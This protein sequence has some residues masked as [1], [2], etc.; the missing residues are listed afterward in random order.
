MDR[1]IRL[2]LVLLTSHTV[3]KPQPF[4]VIIA[5][6][7]RVCTAFSSGFISRSRIQDRRQDFP[8][9]LI[10]WQIASK[11]F[12]SR[13]SMTGR[14]LLKTL[15]Y[16]L[17]WT[18]ETISTV[19]L[20]SFFPV[21]FSFCKYLMDYCIMC[22]HFLTSGVNLAT[23][24]HVYVTASS[25]KTVRSFNLNFMISSIYALVYGL[26]TSRLWLI[27]DKILYSNR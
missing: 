25:S 17:L 5:F 3:I 8:V 21:F 18:I 12:F 14:N 1:S 26:N 20:L 13:S 4:R 6:E 24:L 7:I 27:R 23:F 15:S 10:L 11:V 16:I 9:A 19:T 22:K 2:S